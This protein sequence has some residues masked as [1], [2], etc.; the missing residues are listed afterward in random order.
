[1]GGNMRFRG[2]LFWESRDRQEKLLAGDHR[3]STDLGDPDAGGVHSPA[4][5]P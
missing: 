3:H 2:L 1:M 4:L 5:E